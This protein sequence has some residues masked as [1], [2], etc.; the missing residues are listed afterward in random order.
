M[1]QW[2]NSHCR[3]L[4]KCSHALQISNRFCRTSSIVQLALFNKSHGLTGRIVSFLRLLVLRTERPQ[5]ELLIPPQFWHTHYY[6]THH[7]FIYTLYVKYFTYMGTI[8]PMDKSLKN[9]YIPAFIVSL[10]FCYIWFGQKFN[11]LLICIGAY[12]VTQKWQS[13][14]RTQALVKPNRRKNRVGY[15]TFG[16]SVLWRFAYPRG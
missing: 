2:Q 6:T 15:I 7:W 1:K 5:G 14:D 12:F 4:F 11:I 3:N 10:S 9:F 8:V 13:I 16:M